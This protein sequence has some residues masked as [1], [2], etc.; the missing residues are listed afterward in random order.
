MNMYPIIGQLDQIATEIYNLKLD[1]SV[2]K[3]EKATVSGKNIV[4]VTFRL[5]F[6]NTSYVSTEITLSLI[7][8]FEFLQFQMEAKKATKAHLETRQLPSFPCTLL[9]QLFPFAVL[10]NPEMII[11]GYG[12]KLLEVT[13]GHKILLGEPI[14]KY[15][16]LRRPKGISFSWKNVSVHV[17]KECSCLNSDCECIYY[18]ACA[19]PTSL[20]KSGLI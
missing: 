20:I 14:T 16:R 17:N 11:E 6:D 10:F 15:F 9:L 1:S 18:T 8:I 5:N 4:I 7:Q 19:T 2:I 13:G 3:N 12:E